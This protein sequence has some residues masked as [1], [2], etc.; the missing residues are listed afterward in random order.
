MWRSQVRRMVSEW[1]NRPARARAHV[2]RCRCAGACKCG[3]LVPYLLYREL[4]LETEFY[5]D[6]L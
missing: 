6:I 1:W 3:S 4:E 2:P 5:R